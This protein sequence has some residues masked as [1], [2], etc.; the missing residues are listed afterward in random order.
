MATYTL[1]KTRLHAG[2]WEGILTGTG[3]DEPVLCVTHQGVALTGM[4]AEYD[5]TENQWMVAIPIPAKLISDGVQ[6]FVMSDTNGHT[7][8]SFTL[9]AGDA[10]AEDIRAEVD[11]LR[12]ELDLLKSAFRTHCNNS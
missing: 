12:A 2:V 4:T 10:L 9:L 8:A 7:L 1:T 5:A 11:L 3:P 6:T